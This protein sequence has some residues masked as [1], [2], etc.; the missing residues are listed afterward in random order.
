VIVHPLVTDGTCPSCRRGEDMHCQ[1][2]LFTGIRHD[3]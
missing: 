3:G 1:N 2:G